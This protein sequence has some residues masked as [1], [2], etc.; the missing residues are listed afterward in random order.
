M[1][2]T[3]PARVAVALVG[4]LVTLFTTSG[5][6]HA[7]ELTCEQRGLL[8]RFEVQN[9][10]LSYSY[11]NFEHGPD[12]MVAGNGPGTLIL[13]RTVEAS[14]SFLVSVEVATPVVSAAL[15][16]DVTETVSYTAGF[17]FEIPEEP[18]GN[19][20][21][22]EAGTRDEVHIYDVQTYCGTQ[23]EGGPVRGR[24]EK[25]GHLIYQWWGEPPGNPRN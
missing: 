12:W 16:F 9:A 8:P 20:W 21:F 6:A 1:H 23:P 19:R 22:V 15:G 3:R 7:Q 4:T 17:E 2:T 11:D 18:R 25:T 10:K 14:N 5:V 24:A 13:S